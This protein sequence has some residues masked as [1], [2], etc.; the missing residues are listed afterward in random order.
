MGSEGE[1]SN[2][3]SPIYVAV[4]R[5]V[6]EGKTLLTWA[7]ESFAGRE[8][9]LVHVHQP[10]S[11]ASLLNAKLS[12]SKLKNHAISAC[13]EYERLKME[14]L[15]NQ[16]LIF[17][18]QIGKRADKV[19]IEMRNIEKGIIQLI[20]QHN[21]RQL[22]MGAGAEIFNKKPVGS[23]SHL[24]I[25]AT[26]PPST[27]NGGITLRDTKENV[28]VDGENVQC[29]EQ[30]ITSMEEV[31]STM[32]P[33][34]G[35]SNEDVSPLFMNVELPRHLPSSSSNTSLDSD[36]QE[37]ETY[38][39]RDKL[40]HDKLKH[41]MI[42][43]EISK[44]RAFEESLRRWRAEEDAL[45]A[46]RKADAEESLLKEEINRNR[47]IEEQLLRQ[48]QEL[49]TMKNQH[50]QISK[51]LQLIGAH[52][53]VLENRLREAYC[54]EKELEEKIIQAVNLLITF[55]GTRDKLQIEYDSAIRKVNKYRVLQMEDPSRILH[56]HFFGI[57]FSDIIEATQNFSP[58]QK[59]GEGRY[60]SVF[61]GTLCHVKV[62]IKML[63]SSASQ[64]DSEFKNEIEILCRV[65]HPN[66]VT[67]IGACPESRSLVYEYIENG[68]LEDYLS[69]PIQNHLS[70]QTRIRIAID[71]C[72]ALIFLH[73]D[74]NV[75]GNLKTSNIL[76]DA[77][78]VTKISGF[79]ISNLISRNENPNDDPEKL[80]YVGPEYFEDGKLT[81][82]CDVYSFGVVM[83]RL[84]TA[85]PA[86]SVVRDVK[87][88]VESGNLESV[89]DVLA[90]DWPLGQAEL[91][92]LGLR[93]CERDPSDRPDLVSD[94]WAVLEPMREFC[95]SSELSSIASCVDSTSQLKIPSHFLCPIFQEVMK[96]PHIAGDGYTYEA[97]AIK[98]W[99][100]SGH[101]TSPMTNLKL[102]NCDLIPNYALYYAIQE[103]QQQNK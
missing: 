18:S 32:T 3:N 83:L 72:S 37:K 12:A 100:N 40:E 102:D 70:W 44:K 5:N 8:I 79:G 95:K 17:L 58:S 87:C 26:S 14:K 78:L 9:C 57:L 34:V 35:H 46:V 41:A 29:F 96:D 75:H 42:D 31:R 71:T 73:A 33:M 66:L 81:T 101:K 77:N 92:N 64:S 76:L 82:E 21:I 74:N 23:G 69:N 80:A 55:K 45:V 22:I 98:G 90:G 91:A 1:T 93:C 52:K 4:G 39:I 51:D 27:S 63:P 59:I 48:N 13:Q 10:A 7:V 62:A 6:K 94:V 15:M 88:A 50:D 85:R 65:R 30:P 49:Q 86:T 56:V 36:F 61:K 43:A 19:C 38:D 53:P 54:S 20:I 47:E 84:L 60:G 97:D 2:F 89:L 25:N 68:S 16:Y 28:D 11:L 103:W 67:L 24:T 99:F